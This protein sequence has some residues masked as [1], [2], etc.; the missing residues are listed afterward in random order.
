MIAGHLEQH[1]PWGLGS[2]LPSVRMGLTEHWGFLG[3]PQQRGSAPKTRA[4]RKGIILFRGPAVASLEARTPGCSYVRCPELWGTHTQ[5][6]RFPAREMGLRDLGWGG[7]VGCVLLGCLVG[8][9][10]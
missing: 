10:E 5:C 7:G 9:Q 2:S 8:V 3:K 1:L 6:F 4:A